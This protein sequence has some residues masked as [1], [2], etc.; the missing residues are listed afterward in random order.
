MTSRRLLFISLAILTGTLV[1]ERAEAQEKKTLTFGQ[2]FSNAEPLL[3]QRLPSISGWADDSHYLQMKRKEGD[4]RPRLYAVDVKTGEEKPARDLSGFRD[5]VGKG[6]DLSLPASA[7]E[8]WTRLIF[9]KEGDLYVLNTPTKEFRRLTETAE[10]EKNATL[11]PDGGAL[12]YTRGNDLYSMDLATGKE[13]RHTSD[14]TGLISNGWASWVYMEEILGRAGRYRA[15][16]WSPDSRQILF[17]RFDD[18]KVPEFPL[19]NSRGQH[20]FLEKER[21]PKAGDPNPSVRIG[22]VIAGDPRPPVW[23]AFDQ[24]A[25][26]YFG[27]P[28]WTPGGKRVLVQWMN[29]AQDTLK[30]YDLNPST[31]ERK[32]I[33]VE[34]QESWVDWFEKIPFVGASGDFILKSDRDGWA[35]LYRYSTSGALKSRL[36]FGEWAVSGVELVDT[37]RGVVYFTAK[38]ESSTRTDLYR[39]GLDG[40]GL[41]RLTFGPYTH[42]VTVS[43][44]GSYFLTRY[45]N[46]ETPT[47]A[48]V[49]DADGAL[50]KDLGESTTKAFDDYAL[51]K[52]ELLRVPTPDGYSLPM[53]ITLPAPLEPGRRYPVL[54]DVYGGPGSAAVSER[55]GGLSPQWWA[56]E[57]IIQVAIDHRGSGH[58]GKK[59]EA[60]MHRA[61][62]KWEMN[63][64]I[65]AVKYLRAQPYVDSTKIC[66]TGGSYGGYV[67]AMAL[68]YGADYFTHGIA[69]Y[70]VTDWL[71]Y[72]SHYV[73]RYMDTPAENPEGYHFASVMTHAANYRGLLRI[74]HG[75]MD[76]N[77]HMQNSI[78]LADTLEN[79]GRHF[80]LMLYPGGRHGWGGPKAA[81]LRN[82]TYR[83]Y[84]EKL[85]GKPFPEELFRDLRLRRGRGGEE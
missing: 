50:V 30:L 52:T 11:A 16:W 2:I 43:P 24:A 23:A 8:S 47:R 62:G 4:E 1:Q 68:T 3:L 67:V 53:T 76:D 17:F 56:Q 82:E 65:E 72:D 9:Q 38:K 28:F 81:H 73:E 79:L 78:Q 13:T 66:I 60:L 44:G 29:R 14:G 64:Y 40:R 15:F 21:Y 61:L 27:T 69:S 10:E 5:L 84:Y 37:V 31:G 18:T 25:D 75:T 35:H 48:G 70:S 77:V 36:T 80:E 54:I 57:G 6:V 20:G 45:S 74:V 19:Y 33:F 32:E 58:F 63:D 41:R 83:F 39:V 42:A 46:L 49:Y 59:G 26:Q 85:L 7:N 22:V 34:H 55:W 71:L 12:A 51:A